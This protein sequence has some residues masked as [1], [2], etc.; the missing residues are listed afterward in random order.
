MDPD[1]RRAL[2]RGVGAL[3]VDAARG[4]WAVA[5]RHAGEPPIVGRV[6]ALRDA[7]DAAS[8]S[9]IVGI[10][11]P[12]GLAATG[13]RAADE[14]ARLVLAGH[15]RSRV[16]MTPPRAVVRD[17][18][19]A[20][21]ADL[22]SLSRSLWG[23]GVSAQALALRPRIREIDDLVRSDERARRAIHEVH[24]EV[25]LRVLTDADAPSKH[26]YA[27]MRFRVQALT[28]AFGA[29]VEQRAENPPAGVGTD[30]VLDA[31]LALWSAE[32]I[33]AGS[34]MTWGSGIDEHG[35]SMRIHA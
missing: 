18:R 3:G 29:A 34:A 15:A 7:L 1:L 13:A 30:D 22:Q 8:G 4:R 35:I 19:P 33:A 23:R 16:F 24:P 27:G 14:Q 31:L 28:H 26:T 25:S 17:D 9:P 2:Q 6:D 20:G 5:V 32:R 12:V 11:I 10:D 21:D